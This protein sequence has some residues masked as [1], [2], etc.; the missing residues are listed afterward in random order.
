MKA[1]GI[2]RRVD[3]LGR[4]VLP[5]ELRDSLGINYGDSIEMYPEGELLYIKKHLPECIFCEDTED[6]IEYSNK[7]VCKKCIAELKDL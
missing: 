1:I 6:V 5:K 3:R 7:L 2:A 4:V